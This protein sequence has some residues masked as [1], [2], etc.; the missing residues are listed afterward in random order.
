MGAFQP[1]RFHLRPTLVLNED[2][3]PHALGKCTALF[4]L[5]ALVRERTKFCPWERWI[6]PRMLSVAGFAMMTKWFSSTRLETRTKESNIYA[7]IW[8]CKTLMRNESKV[9]FGPRG[10]NLA[11]GWEALSTDRHLG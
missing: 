7:S 11:F 2:E 6:L 1:V 4:G 3:N 9:G 10:R 5:F 8:G